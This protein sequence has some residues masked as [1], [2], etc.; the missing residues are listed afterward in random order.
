MG[1]GSVRLH[2]G[3]LAEVPDAR[4]EGGRMMTTD[5]GISS[6]TVEGGDSWFH[7]ATNSIDSE[8]SAIRSN[9][10][11]L[12]RGPL[13]SKAT[14]AGNGLDWR[15]T[16]KPYIKGRGRSWWMELG[17]WLSLMECQPPCWK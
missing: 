8:R 13:F 17:M 4:I 9:N 1:V 7:P 5:R 2:L 12:R 16:N 6:L 10:L 3:H 14:E 11:I 15:A